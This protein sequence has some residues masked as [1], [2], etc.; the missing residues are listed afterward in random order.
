MKH[1]VIAALV[2]LAAPSLAN[3]L[4]EPDSLRM[5]RS[6]VVVLGEVHDN[7]GHHEIQASI[8]AE[9]KP[10]AVVFEMLTADQAARVTSENRHSESA[11]KATLEWDKTG[12]PDF[13]SY[14]PIFRAAP[15]ARVFG[16]GLGRDTARAALKGGIVD[17]FGA[18]A[19]RYGLDRPLGEAEQ[20][21]R[22]AFQHRAHCDALPGTMLP[23][24]VDLQRL[25]DAFLARAVVAAL[26]QTGGP[27]V[28]ITGNGHARK[29]WGMAVY[30]NQ[31]RPDLKVFV[32][33]Q[34][35]DGQIDGEFDHVL[36]SPVVEREDP[37][38]AFEKSK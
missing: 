9:L 32:L 37:C 4:P 22:Q 18:D 29:D 24:M 20:D 2:L 17:Y 8:V 27:V 5:A 28:V 1:L 35:E 21:D 33:G 36:D 6:D 7:P 12:W 13:S 10:A 16:A 38:L 19:S 31:A 23:M 11:L 26:E 3:V 14:Y 25:R 15:Q 30:L 34:S